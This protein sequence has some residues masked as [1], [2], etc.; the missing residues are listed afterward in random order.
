VENTNTRRETT[1][2]KKQKS[3]LSTNPEEDRHINIIPPLTTQITG[4]NNHF[5]L[6]SLNIN[7]FN[8]P[9]KT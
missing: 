1:F 4:S 7:G 8:S 6:I 3:Y 5:S 2:Y 9:Q